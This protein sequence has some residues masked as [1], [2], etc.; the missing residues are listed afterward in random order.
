MRKDRHAFIQ[1]VNP[2]NDT[3]DDT[4]SIIDDLLLPFLVELTAWDNDG[5]KLDSIR[6]D[7]FDD[8]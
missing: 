2:V 3:K 5:N 8:D 4:Q 6:L 7:S 1:S